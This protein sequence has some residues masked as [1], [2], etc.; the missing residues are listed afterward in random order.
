[1]DNYKR[2]EDNIVTLTSITNAII[3][4]QIYVQLKQMGE[5]Q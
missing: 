4:Q 2:L 1:M 3:N 5:V